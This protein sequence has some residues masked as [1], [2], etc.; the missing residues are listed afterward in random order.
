[1]RVRRLRAAKIK[2]GMRFVGSAGRMLHVT[3]VQIHAG[4]GDKPSR[5]IITRELGGMYYRDDERL[6]VPV[7]G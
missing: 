5:S 3:G 4:G 2:K 7:G 1:M 6:R